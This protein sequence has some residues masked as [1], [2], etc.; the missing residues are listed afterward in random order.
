MACREGRDAEVPMSNVGQPAAAPFGACLV[1][2]LVAAGGCGISRE[3]EIRLGREVRPRFEQRVGGLADD[4][5]VQA[6]VNA[7]GQR[8]VKYTRRPDL[9]WEFRVLESNRLNAFAL[10]GGFV[11]VTTE[12]LRKLDDEAQ[13]AAVLAHQAGHAAHGHTLRQLVRTQ[14]VPAGD[15]ELDRVAAGVEWIKY[16]KDQEEEADLAGLR[17]LASAGYDP[18]ALIQ[19]MQLAQR[20]AETSGVDSPEFFGTHTDPRDRMAYLREDI[21]REYAGAA[22][23]GRT[24]REQYRGVVLPAVSP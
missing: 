14:I 8:V 9:P 18:T 24:G 11:Y 21:R 6:Y 3:Q 23:T 1:V 13:L 4:E 19:V 22:A 2:A 7:V 16:T 15:A 10:P 12:L 20:E 5:A 17:Y